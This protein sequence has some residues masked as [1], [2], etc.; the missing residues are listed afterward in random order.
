[1]VRLLSF[2]CCFRHTLSYL[3]LTFA[4]VT[5]PGREAVLT[6]FQ[7]GE[8]QEKI[9]LSEIETREEMHEM[10]K[11]KGFVLKSPEEREEAAKE[12]KRNLFIE[13]ER[14]KLKMEYY[15]K[16]REF[17]KVFQKE[18]MQEDIATKPQQS[19]KGRAEAD[20]L[21]EAYDK[22]HAVERYIATNKGSP[23][24]DRQQAQKLKD[25]YTEELKA[26][27]E[28]LYAQGKIP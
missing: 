21:V 25:E 6:I 19:R 9:K 16:Q 17:I 10:M 7:D 24:L 3:S 20:F 11:N 26:R 27:F 14:K 1:M 12:G 22:N 2:S 15:E 13:D 5:V 23:N 18:I 4:V 28:E 8:E